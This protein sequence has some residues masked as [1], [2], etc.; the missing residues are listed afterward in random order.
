[1]GTPLAWRIEQMCPLDIGSRA[2]IMIRIQEL[3]R[4]LGALKRRMHSAPPNN[5][6]VL[7]VGMSAIQ[8]EIADLS[9]K[10]R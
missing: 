6:P 4:R 10:L 3:A 2:R 8:R 9:R 7:Q 5:K 1:M